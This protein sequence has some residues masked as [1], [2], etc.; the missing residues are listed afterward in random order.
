MARLADAK[1]PFWKAVGD[2]LVALAAD[3]EPEVRFRCMKHALPVEASCLYFEA[4]DRMRRAAESGVITF[5]DYAER[6]RAVGTW[7]DQ[8]GACPWPYRECG[9]TFFRN[10]SA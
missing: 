10:P 4:A 5:D 6:L 7:L 3:A 8:R 9:F 2:A 1:E